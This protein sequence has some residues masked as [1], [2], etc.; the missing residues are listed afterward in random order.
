M[1]HFTEI[2]ALEIAEDPGN[3]A[4]S[5]VLLLAPVVDLFDEGARILAGLWL[6]DRD[7]EERTLTLW[8]MAGS[9]PL[10]LELEWFKGICL[11]ASG[12]SGRIVEKCEHLRSSDSLSL[13][14]DGGPFKGRG[15]PQKL[16]FSGN[17]HEVAVA[18]QTKFHR[19][20][21]AYPL[22]IL[23]LA[24][25]SAFI[26]E[27]QLNAKMVEVER[28]AKI[29]A[30]RIEAGR[31]VRVQKAL[32]DLQE[33]FAKNFS[34]SSLLQ[35]SLSILRKHTNAQNCIAFDIQEGQ[36][37]FF[38]TSGSN[39][40]KVLGSIESL[41]QVL[42][43]KNSGFG[44]IYRSSKLAS[45]EGASEVSV[46]ALTLGVAATD[47]QT[48]LPLITLV[49]TGEH[50]INFLGGHFSSTCEKILAQIGAYLHDTLPGFLVRE[51]LATLTQGL[52]ALKEEDIQNPWDNDTSDHF[53]IFCNLVP[54]IVRAAEGCYIAEI[55]SEE[56]GPIAA[57]Y[58]KEGT[59]S[60]FE[61]GHINQLI[62]D[63][64][65]YFFGGKYFKKYTV[66][67]SKNRS[68]FLLLQIASPSLS[69]YEDLIARL[70]ASEVRLYMIQSL[71]VDGMT[72]SIGELRHHLRVA[73]N[74]FIKSAGVLSDIFSLAQE[75]YSRDSS[76]EKQD[77]IDLI[78]KEAHFRKSLERARIS[79]EEV[80]SL[81]EKA[82]VSLFAIDRSQLQI[83]RVNIG[84][85]VREI[86]ALLR[87]ELDRRSMEVDF[88][89]GYPL[90][91]ERPLGD[92]IWLKIAIFNL[93][94]NAIKYGFQGTRIKI[95]LLLS[96]GRWELMI[97]DSGRFIPVHREKE[98]FR[99]Y[100]R[101]KAER[102]IQH[103][104]GTGLGLA[105]AL[106]IIKLHDP[107]GEIRVSSVPERADSSRATTTF[108]ISLPRH[109]SGGA[110]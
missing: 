54:T 86:V 30:F 83:G 12:P 60:E 15:L 32:A 100:T 46:M 98:I 11:N 65:G 22:G 90:D 87:P 80:S 71:D 48:Q 57:V 108:T 31:A 63:H 45:H 35:M 64:E 50:S 2:D 3:I 42:D 34:F 97:R 59:S 28:I 14:G 1:S 76:E 26:S 6:L 89:D 18:L 9:K 75:R 8:A 79:A 41:L 38:A 73:L 84:G 96:R 7:S 74:G 36:R 104:P 47:L 53:S 21:A 70:V 27:E 58:S 110:T 91:V 106:T 69:I 92:R 67:R 77:A 81:F 19:D 102:G 55:K 66:F 13:F 29:I 103:M 33:G 72:H 95:N 78:F 16:A 37:K 39:V 43:S 109:I 93:I 85:V 52:L 82:R 101:L 105:A 88:A 20:D 23:S 5:R 44:K 51:R 62:Q 94:E 25:D 17:M 40:E 61:M 56:S 49:L 68:L 4:A 10:K 99:R 107:S 24:V